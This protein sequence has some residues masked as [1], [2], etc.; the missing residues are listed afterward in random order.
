MSVGTRNFVVVIAP[1]MRTYARIV[2]LG[3]AGTRVTTMPTFPEESM[4]TVPHIFVR[5]QGSRSEA[6][7]RVRRV[8]GIVFVAP[9]SPRQMAW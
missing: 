9:M 7:M 8:S 2:P 3:G 5:P 6:T 4:S 1:T